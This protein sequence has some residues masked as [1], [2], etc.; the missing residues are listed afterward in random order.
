MITC[1]DICE[2]EP[3]D[4]TPPCAR[5]HHTSGYQNQ[6]AVQCQANIA[7]LHPP[8]VAGKKDNMSQPLHLS[9]QHT[10]HDISLTTIQ[11]VTMELLVIAQQL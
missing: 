6:C 5:K 10:L 11:W 1:Y 2:K 9:W 8:S 4:Q 3:G 7:A